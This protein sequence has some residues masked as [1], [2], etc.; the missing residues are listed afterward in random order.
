MLP[1]WKA[2]RLSPKISW[3]DGT[4]QPQSIGI[5]T[6]MRRRNHTL[7][8]LLTELS[9]RQT[10]CMYISESLL[11]LLHDWLTH[12]SCLKGPRQSSAPEAVLQLDNVLERVMLTPKYP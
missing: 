3:L 2:Q 1:A 9:S 5:S 4:F 10:G 12:G 7:V 6:T 11:P 8:M